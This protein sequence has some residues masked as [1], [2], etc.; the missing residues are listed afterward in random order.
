MTDA[1]YAA[2]AA[3]PGADTDA[4]VLTYHANGVVMRPE[5]LREATARAAS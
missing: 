5:A 2:R 1:F 3:G 4:V